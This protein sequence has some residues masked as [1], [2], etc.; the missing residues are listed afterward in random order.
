ME[1]AHSLLKVGTYDTETMSCR[2]L[3]RYIQEILPEGDW[4]QDNMK[5][6]INAITKRLER[7]FVKVHKRALVRVS[8]V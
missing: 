5:L 2:G 3:Q 8:V 6:S 1:V 7:I 4:S